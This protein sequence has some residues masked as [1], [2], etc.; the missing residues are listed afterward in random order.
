[1]DARLLVGSGF[2]PIIGNA[3]TNGNKQQNAVTSNKGFSFNEL[4]QQTIQQTNPRKDESF[5][6]STHAQK[7]LSERSI[8]MSGNLE[9]TLSEAF[10]ELEAK[11]AR[12][13]LVITDQGAF[14]INVPNRTLVTA[15]DISEMKDGIVTN[16]DSVNMKLA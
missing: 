2:R 13:S 8:T 3:Q 15:M 1:M 14:V 5:H 7:R 6:I 16:I 10:S 9:N 12:N 11:G 4:F